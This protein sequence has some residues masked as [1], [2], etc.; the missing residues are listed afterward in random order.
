MKNIKDIAKYILYSSFSK[1]ISITLEKLYIILYYCQ[2][3]F[4]R[5]L[6]FR[7]FKDEE[8]IILRTTE[9]KYSTI[10]PFYCKFKGKTIVPTVVLDN[11]CLK[12]DELG[13]LCYLLEEKTK[14]LNFSKNEI[15]LIEKIILYYGTMEEEDLQKKYFSEIN[16]IINIIMGYNAES[17]NFEDL[18][19]FY[20]SK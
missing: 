6:R 4:I 20:F 9:P 16:T 7:L 14:D 12:L 5:I 19:K 10:E 15:E 11:D 18:Y 8:A 13:Y 2:V 3:N 1:G 17:I